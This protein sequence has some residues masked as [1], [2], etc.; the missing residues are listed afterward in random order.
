MAGI[1]RAAALA[2]LAHALACL[3]PAEVSLATLEQASS[4][5][6]SDALP[7]YQGREVAVAGQVSSEPVLT[8]DRY[9]LPIQDASFHGLS[10]RG[11]LEEFAF[12][13]P[14]DWVQARGTIGHFAGLVV[15]LPREIQKISHGRTPRAKPVKIE[16]L[17][18]FRYLGTLVSLQ[19]EVLGH[20]QKGGRDTLQVRQEGQTI[21]V[22]LGPESADLGTNPSVRVGTL[23][24]ITG[25]AS[26]YCPQPPYN[27]SFQVLVPDP[28][29]LGPMA[30][31]IPQ[32]F[33]NL[34]PWAGLTLTLLS[35][36]VFRERYL[37]GRRAALRSFHQASEEVLGAVSNA[38]ILSKVN[39]AIL[40]IADGL[41]AS[42]Y[43]YNRGLEVLELVPEGQGTSASSIRPEG[44]V[45]AL[46]SGVSLCFRNRTLLNVP[47]TQRSP[48]FNEDDKKLLPR[49][50]L[51]VPMV[52]PLELV[53][54]LQ[55]TRERGPYSFSIELQAALQH[56][57]NQAAGAIQMRERQDMRERLFQTEKL[58]AAGQLLSGIAGE[59]RSPIGSI[60]ELTGAL[61][62]G[63]RSEREFERIE[64]KA[65]QA[66]EIVSRLVAFGKADRSE[67]QP[68]D[69]QA[70]VTRLVHSP[71]L[72]RLPGGE[73]KCHFI[74][75]RV[76][77][78]GSQAQL[79]Q[80][81]LTAH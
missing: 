25:I 43:V 34:L 55:V 45:G 38:E 52:T 81:F 47:D 48:F 67:A 41:V 13:S 3:C 7:A 69:L 44:P 74:N 30:G 56:L 73:P 29:K 75:A 28:S 60:L 35:G 49:S 5:I 66:S 11:S 8:G 33:G 37:S 9:L 39:L 20:S 31:L 68:V 58:A 54:V 36:W 17:N 77:V 61:T 24:S 6:G 72:A 53:G 12:L 14:G 1:P 15:L 18:S 42:L 22:V 64:A 23:V 76:M 4:R 40:E 51:F 57:A 80:V 19:G 27:R 32:P 79:E 65:L 63:K 78:V 26:Q 62:A 16:D 50:I 46:A 10:L 2:L 21:D 70:L 59:L 71:A